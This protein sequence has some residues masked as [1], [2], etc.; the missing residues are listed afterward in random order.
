MRGNGPFTMSPTSVFPEAVRSLP[1]PSPSIAFKSS[2]SSVGNMDDLSTPALGNPSRPSF[3]LSPPESLA[4][5]EDGDVS[6]TGDSFLSSLREGSPSG[7]PVM[8]DRHSPKGMHSLPKITYSRKVCSKGNK[9]SAKEA[10]IL[11]YGNDT[12]LESSRKRIRVVGLKNLG[13]TC[14]NNAVIQALSHTCALREYFLQRVPPVTEESDASMSSSDSAA[15]L[16]LHTARPRT[17]RAARLEEQVIVPP[18]INLCDEFSRLLKMMWI[19]RIPAQV[20]TVPRARRSTLHL[21]PVIS[22]HK[23]ASA[24]ATVLPSFHERHEQQD[25]QEFLRCS[26]ERMQDELA[27]EQIEEEDT[28]VQTVF[29]GILWNKIICHS[30]SEY[31]IKPDPF[32]DLSLVIPE[33]L[34]PVTKGD[35]RSSTLEECLNLFAT[36]EELEGSPPPASVPAPTNGTTRSCLS[37]G[38]EAAFSKSIAF[39]VLPHVLCIHLKRFRWRTHKIRGGKQKVDTHVRFPLAG[40]DMGAWCERDVDSPILYDL[41]AV[42]VHQG[43]GANFGHYVA[44]TKHQEEWW[45]LDDDRIT[46]VPS[47]SVAKSKAYLLFYKRRD[48]EISCAIADDESQAEPTDESCNKTLTQSHPDLTGLPPNHSKEPRSPLES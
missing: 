44:Y 27:S 13:N 33:Q 40:L 42:V 18:N 16:S 10:E 41:Y 36:T 7:T 2:A 43:T 28:I 48:D 6:S 45:L 37:C 24:V 32:L 21:S 46:K 9:R 20:R 34:S 35:V 12:S 15:T 39:G 8:L 14:Y 4:T 17:R 1:S 19:N 3:T 29:G 25:A 47:E 38:S 31:T 30:C 26:L 23:F 22:P 5:L 11:D